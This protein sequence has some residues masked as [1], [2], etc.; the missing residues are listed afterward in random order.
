[1]TFFAFSLH[2]STSERSGTGPRPTAVGQTPRQVALNAAFSWQV[3]PTGSGDSGRLW[4]K[5][6]SFSDISVHR[7]SLVPLHNLLGISI[8]GLTCAVVLVELHGNLV[9]DWSLPYF[10]LV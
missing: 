6:L 3:A 8:V 10:A 5:R 2:V 4:E 9:V 1:M 7:C